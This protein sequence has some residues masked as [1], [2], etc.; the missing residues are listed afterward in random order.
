MVP[1]G[2]PDPPPPP[3][4]GNPHAAPP[5]PGVEK[6]GHKEAGRW[7]DDPP[8]A[9]KDSDYYPHIAR[10]IAA[11]QA[12][13]SDLMDVIE[14]RK[15][16][17]S[18]AARRQAAARY[19]EPTWAAF[20]TAH[21]QLKEYYPARE[22]HA[23]VGFTQPVRRSVLARLQAWLKFWEVKPPLR[24]QFHLFYDLS[25]APVGSHLLTRIQQIA[26]EA[27]RLLPAS[28][29]DDCFVQ[30][31]SCATDLLGLLE[32]KPVPGSY[33]S[34]LQLIEKDLDDI[35]TRYLR[36]P[37]RIYYFNGVVAG[38][39]LAAAITLVGKSLDLD[40]TF[41]QMWLAGAL[42]GMLSVL[43]RM[44]DEGLQIRYTV[45]PAFIRL[46]GTLRPLL[47]GFAGILALLIV[48]TQILPLPIGTD[49]SRY[50]LILLALVAGF[51]ERS[52]PETL[53]RVGANSS[54]PPGVRRV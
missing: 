48:L 13:F 18:S 40:Q 35:E 46:T 44:S 34:E 41:L 17:T 32:N 33:Q 45:G 5:A 11:G 37:A 52:I 15:D 8:E 51:A 19:L 3:D 16:I 10:A 47:G 39:A 26:T 24:P 50:Y 20:E 29:L 53:E 21:G 31:Y 28:E 23:Y 6:N 1:E 30:L 36:T 14:D 7:A 42:G 22:I 54:P 4:A 12:S 49:A 38:M 27:D 2:Q 9:S 25:E 43:H